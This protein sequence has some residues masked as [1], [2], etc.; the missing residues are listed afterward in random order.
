MLQAATGQLPLA[1]VVSKFVE[2]IPAHCPLCKQG[3][4]SVYHRVFECPCKAEERKKLVT[5]RVA[6]RAR[7]RGEKSLLLN[8]G[9]A[10]LPS[11]LPA[12]PLEKV[13]LAQWEYPDGTSR[14]EFEDAFR[15]EDGHVYTDGSCFYSSCK[16]LAHAG[17]AAVQIDSE[18]QWTKALYGCVPDAFSQ[19]AVV[20]EHVAVVFVAGNAADALELKCDCAAVVNGFAPGYKHAAGPE[21]PQAGFWREVKTRGQWPN[22]QSISKVKA[23][24]ALADASTHAELLDIQGNDKAD[25]FAK[26]GAQLH[27]SKWSACAIDDYKREV[28]TQVQAIRAVG[29]MLATYPSAKLLWPPAET[30]SS[31]DVAGNDECWQPLQPELSLDSEHAQQPDWE[32]EELAALELFGDDA[33]AM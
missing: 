32:G 31:L 11:G 18:G 27:S 22:L 2:G 8:R 21:R 9:I 4:D 3:T 5:P 14:P 33:L 24:L 23:H 17:W 6:A 26:K 20:A 28:S 16:D 19:A 13:P 12:R 15:A 25:F 7:E 29:N 10:V 1:S 30:P